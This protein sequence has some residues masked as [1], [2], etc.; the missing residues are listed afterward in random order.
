[1]SK[2]TIDTSV[3]HC[4]DLMLNEVVIPTGANLRKR[5]RNLIMLI[6]GL[7][8]LL[9]TTIVLCEAYETQ[10]EYFACNRGKT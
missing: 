1:M 5:A 7:G 8:I 2:S 6:K 3:S 4:V 9:V 10:D